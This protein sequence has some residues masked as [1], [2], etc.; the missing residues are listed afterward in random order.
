MTLPSHSCIHC[1]VSG[2]RRLGRMDADLSSIEFGRLPCPAR[3]ER[4]SPVGIQKVPSWQVW[5]LLDLQV[6]LSP[7][8]TTMLLCSTT[9]H[10]V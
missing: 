9:S 3:G 1:F 2:H 10:W 6:C 7:P 8:W 4:K 5:P